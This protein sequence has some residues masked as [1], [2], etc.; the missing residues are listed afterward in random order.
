MAEL[1][2]AWP[3]LITPFTTNNEVNPAAVEKLVDY[4]LG[5]GVNGFYA[6]G[7]T[8]SGVF[9]SVAERKLVAETVLNTVQGRVP[10]IVHVGAISLTDAID[11]ARHALA[12]GAA[13]FSSIIPPLYSGI[14]SVYAYYETLASAVPDLGFFPYIARPQLD[15][16]ELVKRLSALP[17]VVGTKYTGPNMYEF[18]QIAALRDS[19]WTVFSGM[20]EQSVFAAMCNSSGHIGSTLNYMPGAYARIRALVV[21]GQHADAVALQQ[22]VNAVTERLISCGFFGA[23]YET[24]RLLGIDCGEPRLPSVPLSPEAKAA[25]HAALESVG[26]WDLAAM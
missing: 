18:S 12:H 10:V 8:G 19:N 7:S 24:V 20:D 21:K 17:N 3:A 11:L 14:D 4:H 15:S 2:G 13:G 23:L 6:C 9:Q 22:R 26:F 5:K 16:L 25:L 1:F